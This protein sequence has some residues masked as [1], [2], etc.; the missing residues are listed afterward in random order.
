MPNMGGWEWVIVLVI[1]LLVFGVG[2]VGQL[3]KELGEGIK[4]FRQGI[5]EGQDTNSDEEAPNEQI[6]RR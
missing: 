2:R 4:A 5:R 3:G 6:S 1:V